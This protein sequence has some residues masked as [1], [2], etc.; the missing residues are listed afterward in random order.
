L[1]SS[2]SIYSRWGFVQVFQSLVVA[3][4]SLSSFTKV[5]TTGGLAHNDLIN[6][7]EG[8]NNIES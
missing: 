3:I 1:S 5:G 8:Q 4:G 2:F 6:L 7:K